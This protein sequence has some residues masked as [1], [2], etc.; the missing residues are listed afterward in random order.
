MTQWLLT[1]INTYLVDFA[2]H[3]LIAAAIL[4]IGF[5]VCKYIVK[6]V[7]KTKGYSKL[8]SNV[9]SF[10]ANI[11]DAVLKVL[12][13][14]SA[15]LVL[16]VPESTVIAVLGSCGLAIGL[17][18]QGGLSNIASGV[19]IMCCKP[20]H[21]GDFIDNGTVSGT[22]TDIGIYYTSIRTGDNRN[23]VVPNSAMANSTITNLSL[24]KERRIDFD[25][26]ISYTAD[27]DLTRKVLLA[28]AAVNDLVMKD[29]APQVFVAAHG[30][31]AVTVKLRVWV[32][33]EN[34]WTVYF[35]MWEDVKKAFDKFNIEIP[36]QYMNVL[37]TNP[38]TE[39]KAEVTEKTQKTE[40]EKTQKSEKAE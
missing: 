26:G 14:L 12:I 24:A 20:F 2:I 34:Y 1:F 18:L 23:I 36:Y 37:I 15:V 27:I 35:D 17:A 5:P 33:S 11:L 28:T 8:D 30:E 19:M 6:T 7:K 3:L 9:Q 39:E 32:E 21:I 29:P 10:L 31:S 16:G 38:K 25:F 4:I 22:V 40:T 13:I